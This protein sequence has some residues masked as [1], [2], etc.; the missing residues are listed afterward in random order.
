MNKL[1][2]HKKI[3]FIAVPIVVVLLI[4]IIAAV[5]LGG[6]D[7]MEPTVNLRTASRSTDAAVSAGRV[8]TSKEIKGH[9]LIAE[10]AD[11][12]LYLK[13]EV[14][15]IIVRDKATGATMESTVEEDD[16]KSNASWAGFMKCGI[17][18]DVQVGN[19]T[20]QKKVDILSGKA[21]VNVT[22]IDGGFTA[23]IDY[24]QYELG[25]ELTVL[26]YDDGSIEASIPESSIYEN[27]ATNQI[28]NIYVFPMLGRTHLGEMGGYMIV[29]DG[30]GALINLNDKEGRFTA[31]YTQRVFGSDVGIT[32]SFVLSL[33]WNK[34]E[35]IN[36][37]EYILAPVYGMVH[38][39]S[40]MAYLAVI[41]SGAE[42]A[43][44]MAYP[45]G[46]FSDFN[47]VSARF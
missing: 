28:G 26:L 8:D 29:P 10:N 47:G 15:S 30:N 45:N 34:Y 23:K 39:D 38:S 36:E 42:G 14:L 31:P 19:T 35:T 7:A 41:T 40:D 16:G 18:L 5:S 13:K 20:Q 46:V 27:S 12:E 43:T 33:F 17:N 9:F 37:S 11:Y 3:L 24:P 21:E 1:K 2:E 32:E 4:V 6:D 25:F 22:Q 44:V